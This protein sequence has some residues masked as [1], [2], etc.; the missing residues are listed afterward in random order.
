MVVKDCLKNIFKSLVITYFSEHVPE[1]GFLLK[2]YTT[3]KNPTYWKTQNTYHLVIWFSEIADFW[4]NSSVQRLCTF[5]NAQESSLWP[6]SNNHE[7]NIFMM[8]EG[9]R[10][11]GAL[12]TQCNGN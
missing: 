7:I 11:N 3:V 4:K 10:V 2:D 5:E 12:P 1:Q 8:T 6:P 9:E